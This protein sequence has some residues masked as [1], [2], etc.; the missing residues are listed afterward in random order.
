L[1]CGGDRERLPPPRERVQTCRV[2]R[3]LHEKESTAARNLP[4]ASFLGRRQA[5]TPTTLARDVASRG[6]RK[7]VQR[8]SPVPF[9]LGFMKPHNYREVLRS[10]WDNKRRPSFTWRIPRDGV[11]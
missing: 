3:R 1:R 8:V 5:N 10:A 2:C 7:G 11:C 6:R 4:F 9:G